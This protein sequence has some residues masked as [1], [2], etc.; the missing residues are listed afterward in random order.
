MAHFTTY[1]YN[2]RDSHFSLLFAC[3]ENGIME[4]TIFD[5]TW[6]DIITTW[7]NM[8]K[9]KNSNAQLYFIGIYLQMCFSAYILSTGSSEQH[10]LVR[11]NILYAP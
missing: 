1:E 3:V 8:Q 10:T 2:L 4:V 6:N 9:L 5:S 11:M 7:I